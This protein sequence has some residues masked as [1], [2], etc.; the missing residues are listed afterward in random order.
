MRT[1]FHFP[2][3]QPVQAYDR[4]CDSLQG[5]ER[6]LFDAMVEVTRDRNNSFIAPANPGEYIQKHEEIRSLLS[7]RRLLGGLDTIFDLMEVVGN[8]IQTAGN[9]VGLTTDQ[10][11]DVLFLE[12][13]DPNVSVRLNRDLRWS[14]VWGLSSPIQGGDERSE[15][16]LEVY[17][18]DWGEVVPKYVVDYINMAV[19]AHEQCLYGPAVALISI[20]IE[21]TL[22][23]VLEV[24]GFSFNPGASVVDIYSYSDAQVGVDGNGYTVSF[25]Q[26]MPKS[27]AEFLTS[28]GGNPFVEISVRRKFNQRR[29][30]DLLVRAKPCLIDHWSRDDIQQ[31]AQP[32]VNGLGEA[33]DI[34]RNQEGFLTPIDLPTDFDEVI[35][36]VRNNLI[37][38]SG[39]ALTTSLNAV[40]PTG[41]TSLGDFLEDR[42]MIYDLVV[43]VPRFINT[44]YI[45]L[46]Q[47]GHLNP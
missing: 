30:F 15:I 8:R 28:T 27:P 22:R 12:T 21:A 45:E 46:R 33:L 23:D 36:L 38:L 25:L 5:N 32:R 2:Q 14:A 29:E 40:D 24:R 7:Y 43:N 17:S 6:I 1:S 11:F 9:L 47:A 16:A 42:E 31:P 26:P 19:Y 4:L 41:N 18:S 13:S 37:H 10:V 3:D 44:Q 39:E 34:A 20:A 35:Q